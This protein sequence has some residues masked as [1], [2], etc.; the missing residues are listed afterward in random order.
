MQASFPSHSCPAPTISQYSAQNHSLPSLTV[1]VIIKI[2]HATCNRLCRVIASSAGCRLSSRSLLSAETGRSFGNQSF[3]P[4]SFP[5]L[6]G[7]MQGNE[8]SLW[9]L[10][11]FS[12]AKIPMDLLETSSAV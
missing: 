8:V 9:L 3:H 12:S 6:S 11:T 2:Y 5:K 4:E 10:S 1:K 7:L